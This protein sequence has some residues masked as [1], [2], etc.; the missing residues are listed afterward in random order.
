MNSKIKIGLIMSVITL[1]FI[2]YAISKAHAAPNVGGP[3]FPGSNISDKVSW[4]FTTNLVF[5]T[6]PNNI[7]VGPVADDYSNEL[8]QNLGVPL[9]NGMIKQNWACVRE[10]PTEV[11]GGG[12]S[13]SNGIVSLYS[14]VT[15]NDSNSERNV[16]Y[17]R[18]DV[19]D[20]MLAFVSECQ[21]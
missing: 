15:C 6:A 7:F 12:F 10:A 21:R 20:S 1:I 13:C 9:P 11:A 18:Y 4:H 16:M 5:V 14:K 17:I 19:N 8:A 2:V 3:M